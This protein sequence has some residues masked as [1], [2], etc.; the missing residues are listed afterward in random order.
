MGGRPET[1]APTTTKD[2]RRIALLHTKPPIQVDEDDVPE[3][4]YFLCPGT[5]KQT[6]L[7]PRVGW[8]RPEQPLAQCPIGTLLATNESFAERPEVL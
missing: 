3:R 6:E 1:D 8:L 4:P 5:L 7:S 2:I